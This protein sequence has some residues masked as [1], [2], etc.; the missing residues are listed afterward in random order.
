MRVAMIIHGYAPRIGG[1]ERQLGALAPVLK[2]RGV[3]VTILTRR[4]PHTSAFEIIDGI[5]VY[6]FP[7]PGPKP[8]A[9]LVFT[10]SI[11]P[12]IRKLS[13]DLIHAHEFIS[14][15]TTAWLAHR[16]YKIPFILTPHLS[17][18]QGD[19]L[20]MQRKF[21]GQ[22]RLSLFRKEASAF[23]SISS[24]IDA[25]LE[26]MGIPASQRH[27]IG[28]GVDTR[29]FTPPEQPAKQ[30]LRAELGLPPQSLVAVFV[31]RLVPI[32]RL[33]ILIRIWPLVR[34]KYPQAILLIAGTGPLE[35]EL[36]A[37]A[38]DGVRFLGSQEDIAPV[39]QASDL[40]LL[41][42][43]AEGLPVAL[44]EAM[45]CGLAC[46]TTSVGGIPDVVTN[47]QD[48][49]LVPVNDPDAFLQATLLLLERPDMRSQIGKNA[50]ERILQKYS[51]EDMASR[52]I[53]LYQQIIHPGGQP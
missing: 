36:K 3:D 29:R 50:R 2:S 5:P 31:G 37:A 53:S 42:S 26:G 15:A 6:R 48:G 11:L 40:F 7:I 51:V 8:L 52:L 32:K 19:V 46:V 9:A 38:P 28:N 47:H 23:I 10:L 35:N 13:P 49:V 33:D 4:L 30:R 27:A 24:E 39:L 44:L 12:M 14:P 22:A 1:A 20:R 21:L 17:G 18:P 34:A 41:S 45:S 43:D 16:L 25:E